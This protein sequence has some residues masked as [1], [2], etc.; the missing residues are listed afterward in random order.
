MDETA[1]LNLEIN[2]FVFVQ[3]QENIV[4]KKLEIV[5]G[6][7]SRFVFTISNS[8]NKIIFSLIF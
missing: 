1:N 6:I 5:R 4:G 7:N 3:F 2:I 8:E